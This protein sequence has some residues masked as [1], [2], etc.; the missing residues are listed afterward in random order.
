MLISPEATPQLQQWVSKDAI[1][2]VRRPYQEGDLE[3]YKLAFA[4]TNQ[5]QINVQITAEATQLGLLC[6]VADNPEEGHFHVPAV[7]RQAELVVSVSTAGKN[8]GKAKQIRD[9][10]AKWLRHS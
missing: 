9:K 7:H 4:A 10:I 6:N 2:W 1:E 3:G 5:R 8:P